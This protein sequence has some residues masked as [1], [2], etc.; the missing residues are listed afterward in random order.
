MCFDTYH[1]SSIRVLMCIYIDH[2]YYCSLGKIRACEKKFVVKI[3][4]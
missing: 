3:L 1:E 4:S 2:A